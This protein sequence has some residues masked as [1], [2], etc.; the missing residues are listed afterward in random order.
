MMLPVGII[1]GSYINP[2]TI[3]LDKTTSARLL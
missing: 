2:L 3:A 1:T